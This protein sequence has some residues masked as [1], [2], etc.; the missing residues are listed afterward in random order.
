MAGSRGLSKYKL[1]LSITG[2]GPCYLNKTSSVEAGSLL[3]ELKRVKGF[4]QTVSWD[5]ISFEWNFLN[6][7]C[8][9]HF[10]HANLTV[11]SDFSREIMRTC[12][13]FFLLLLLLISYFINQVISPCAQGCSFV[14]L[15]FLVLS[16]WE[17]HVSALSQIKHV[18]VYPSFG[19]AQYLP[20]KSQR[21]AAYLWNHTSL[22]IWRW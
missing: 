10:L 21:L 14:H 5:L 16:P 6:F 17:V 11:E 19:G 22:Y 18:V 8:V 9:L 13:S 4:R 7:S 12:R 20:K 15:L 3:C 1:E 2:L